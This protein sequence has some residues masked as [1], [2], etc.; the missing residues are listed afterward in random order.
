MVGYKKAETNE[1]LG[2][3]LQLVGIP[4]DQGKPNLLDRIVGSHKFFLVLDEAFSFSALC[5]RHIGQGKTLR[6]NQNYKNS[7]T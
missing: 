1:F 3:L 7:N 2:P 5:G 4:L 6:T